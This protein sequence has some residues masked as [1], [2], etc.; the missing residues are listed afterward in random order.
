MSFGNKDASK[1]LA[2]R[3]HSQN[4]IINVKLKRDITYNDA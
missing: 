3:D 2:N 1:L 4:K